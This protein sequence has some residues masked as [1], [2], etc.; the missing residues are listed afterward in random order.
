MIGLHEGSYSG[1]FPVLDPNPPLFNV[2]IHVPWR[3]WFSQL[4]FNR[5]HRCNTQHKRCKCFAILVRVRAQLRVVRVWLEDG[6]T[7][8]SVLRVGCW[9]AWCGHQFQLRPASLGICMSRLENLLLAPIVV[10][11]LIAGS[12][13][14][15]RLAGGRC[16]GFRTNNTLVQSDR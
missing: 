1:S 6:K 13:C 2:D 8:Q 9:F 11:Y 3:A 5:A 4:H 12:F 14:G 15:H 7:G 16:T 10:D